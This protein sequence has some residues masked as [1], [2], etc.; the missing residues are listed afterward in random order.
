MG[1][2]KMLS[3]I[4][5]CVGDGRYFKEKKKKHKNSFFINC[6]FFFAK[7][8]FINLGF[9]RLEKHL[10]ITQFDSNEV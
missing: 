6:D 2:I 5:N 10:D 9:F 7:N 3:K 1:F 8:L 4:S